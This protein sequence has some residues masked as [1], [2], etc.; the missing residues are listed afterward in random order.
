MDAFFRGFFSPFKVALMGFHSWR[1]NKQCSSLSVH[2]TVCPYK[3]L[4]AG[5]WLQ[6]DKQHT[7]INIMCSERSGILICIINNLLLWVILQ[8]SLHIG[9]GVWPLPQTFTTSA[10]RYQ[11]EPQSFHFGYQRQ[12]AAQRGCSVL[13]AAFKRYFTLIFPNSTAGK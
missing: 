7:D 2:M 1:I 13:D 4:R 6:F 12:S 10:V 5:I 3:H 8:G 9:E 11:L